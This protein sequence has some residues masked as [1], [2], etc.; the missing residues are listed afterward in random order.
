MEINALQRCAQISRHIALIIKFIKYTS[1]HSECNAIVLFHLF[2]QKNDSI[3]SHEINAK[4][5]FYDQFLSK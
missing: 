3:F 4:T 1:K 5:L 2:K